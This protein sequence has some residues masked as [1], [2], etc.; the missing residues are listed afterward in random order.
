MTYALPR[1]T[2]KA[3]DS[4]CFTSETVI[5]P[6]PLAMG[7]MT[8]IALPAQKDCKRTDPALITLS[9]APVQMQLSITTAVKDNA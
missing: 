9:N 3:R 1:T 5:R 7:G 6:A 2:K 4:L 8:T